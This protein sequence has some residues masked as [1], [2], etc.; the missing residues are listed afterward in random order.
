MPN[1]Q[2][3]LTN[4][5]VHITTFIA[6][7]ALSMSSVSLISPLRPSLIFRHL[8]H[9]RY[10]LALR[11]TYLHRLAELQSANRTARKPSQIT[12]VCDILIYK[13]I[14]STCKCMRTKANVKRPLSLLL[15]V[16][17]ASQVPLITP[18]HLRTEILY[19]IKGT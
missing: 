7:H 10:H 5:Y 4:Q 2:R 18:K 3:F 17:N 1:N 13:H 15:R 8:R 9:Q 6:T 11:H 14:A 16:V 12:A 19:A